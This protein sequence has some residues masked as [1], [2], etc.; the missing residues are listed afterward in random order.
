MRAVGFLVS[1]VVDLKVIIASSF[2]MYHPLNMISSQYIIN[3]NCALQKDGYFMSIDIE[4]GTDF[5][6]E[7]NKS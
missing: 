3:L 5:L 4:A 6:E 7:G 2:L 1:R